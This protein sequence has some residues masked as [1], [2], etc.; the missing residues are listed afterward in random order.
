M[1]AAADESKDAALLGALQES[2]P[3]VRRPFAAIGERCGLSESET[4][5]RIAA[6]KEERVIRQI[7][8]IF[9][10]RSLGYASSL[11]AARIAPEK[12]ESAVQVINAHPG[13]SHNYLRNHDFNLWYTIAVP[14]D[15]R[16]G[17]EGTVDRLHEL[18]GA[19][20]TRLLPTLKLFKIGVR[21]D[22]GNESKPDDRAA[23]AYTEASRRESDPLTGAEI[24][25]VRLMQRDL[26]LVPEPFVAV[27]GTLGMGFDEAAAMHARFLGNGRMR[28][29]AAVLHHRKAGFRANA[30]GVWAGPPDDAEALQR[31]GERMAEF[32]AVSHCYQRPSYP[33]WPYNLFTMVHGKSAGECEATLDAIAAET[34]I[35]ER[36]ALYSTEEFKK[37]RVRYFTGEERAWEEDFR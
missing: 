1:N 19:E 32:Q 24:E 2:I 18:S 8:A 26:E 16:L 37:V 4:L 27:A 3:F 11:V 35:R 33:D 6:L 34:G 23:P 5:N 31:L 7:S 28:R 14:P 17:L 10:T 21:F 13:V 25:F 36:M 22:V 15:S 30:M 9:D 20:S 29:F 12:I